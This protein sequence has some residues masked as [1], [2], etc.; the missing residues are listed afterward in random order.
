MTATRK[1]PLR[2]CL[3]CRVMKPKR[4]LIRVVRSPEGE[5]SLDLK[6]KK[7]GRG[8]YVCPDADCLKRAEKS[9]ALSRALSITIP[10]DIMDELHK[11]ITEAAE[12]LPAGQTLTPS[13]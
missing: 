6:G 3:G 4:E 9:R 7:S 10:Q 8:A 5:I 11:Q 2:Q 13:P 12:A 1:T